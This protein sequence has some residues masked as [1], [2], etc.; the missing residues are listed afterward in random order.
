MKLTL[1]MQKAVQT[2]QDKAEYQAREE[3]EGG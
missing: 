3:D 2:V 1:T